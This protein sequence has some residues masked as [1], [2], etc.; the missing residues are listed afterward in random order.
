MTEETSVF[1][2]FSDKVSNEEKKQVARK[3]QSF[4][5]ELKEGVPSFPVVT[6]NTKLSSLIG[7]NSWLLFKALGIGSE[8][9]STSVKTWEQN[10]EYIKAKIFLKNIRVVNDVAERGVKLMQDFLLTLSKDEQ[11]KQNILQSVESHRRSFSDFKN[12]H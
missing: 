2:L 6:K 7:K 5:F 10:E 12:L 1:S 11:N 8:W 3:L 9:L 4:P